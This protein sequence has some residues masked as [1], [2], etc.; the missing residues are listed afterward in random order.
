MEIPFDQI[1]QLQI[2]LR[3]QAN[4]SSYYPEDD[5]VL[6]PNLP[7]TEEAIAALDPSPP[8]LRCKHCKGR[9]LRGVQSFICV[10]CGTEACNDV[11]PDPI[12]FRNTIG[13]RW[14]LGSFSLD[15]SVCLQSLLLFFKFFFSFNLFI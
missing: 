4:L 7:S 8:Y 2:S 11:P 6:L 9:L 13:F 14:F 3:K 1:K 10:F 12:N 5:D 15:G